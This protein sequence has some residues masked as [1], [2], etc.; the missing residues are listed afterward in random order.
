MAGLASPS[1]R[2]I[3]TCMP[4]MQANS[5]RVPFW[6]RLGFADVDLRRRRQ[7]LQPVQ[8]PAGPPPGWKDRHHV[9]GA[10]DD[11]FDPVPESDIF[12]KPN[13]SAVSAFESYAA[14]DRDG[15][16]C[17]ARSRRVSLRHGG[18]RLTSMVVLHQADWRRSRPARGRWRQCPWGLLRRHTARQ[19]SSC[20]PTGALM[21]RAMRSLRRR[22]RRAT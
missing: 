13:S 16:A 18:R 6:R 17:Q 21:A 7:G 8:H 20:R 4:M 19:R 1:C 10:L 22:R 3:A 15:G 12:G 11:A 2:W 14:S 5:K 9:A